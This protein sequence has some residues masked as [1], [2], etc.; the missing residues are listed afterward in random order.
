[1]KRVGALLLALG[2]GPAGPALAQAP[3]KAAGNERCFAV[4]D[5]ARPGTTKTGDKVRIALEKSGED[6][7]VTRIEPVKQVDRRSPG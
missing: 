3:A 1:M 6:L 4:M 7:V 2:Y 5:P